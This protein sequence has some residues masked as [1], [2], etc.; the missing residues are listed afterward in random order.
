MKK[1]L[2][3]IRGAVGTALTWAAG[4]SVVGAIFGTVLGRDPAAL[5][6]LAYSFAIP[7][8]IGGAIFSAVLGIVEGRRRFDQMSLPRFAVWGALGGGLL[9]VLLF[10]AG[11]GVSLAQI[12]MIGA[13][14]DFRLS[15]Y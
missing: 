6:G 3:R 1:W 10:A 2:R 13:N 9:S 11:S 15:K 7:G 12:P 4:W 14:P 5:L 8:F